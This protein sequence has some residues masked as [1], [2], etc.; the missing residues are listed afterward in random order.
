MLIHTEKDLH[1]CKE[2]IPTPKSRQ[3][4]IA[5]CSWTTAS[6]QMTPV[7]FKMQDEDGIIQTFDKI[8]VNCC[9]KKLYAGIP[10]YEFDCNILVNGLKLNVFLLYYPESCR[11]V[12]LEK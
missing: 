10:S 11:W 6:G 4:D 8:H 9:E 5:C 3:K 1:D 12:L 2:S 7:F